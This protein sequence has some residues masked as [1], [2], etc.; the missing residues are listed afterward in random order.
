MSVTQSYKTDTNIVDIT[1]WR[2]IQRIKVFESESVKSTNDKSAKH[3]TLLSLLLLQ[4]LNKNDQFL[5]GLIE[6]FIRDT[7]SY[8]ATGDA[9][10]SAPYSL[11][12]IIIK[13]KAGNG[14]GKLRRLR[15]G[16]FFR[17]AHVISFGKSGSVA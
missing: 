10:A 14:S 16:K 17:G 12:D 11:K 2:S 8:E 6:R 7:I 15:G 1:Q 13:T 9:D 5:L 4:G 3:L